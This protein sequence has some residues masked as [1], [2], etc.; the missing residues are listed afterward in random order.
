MQKDN[1]ILHILRLLG[2]LSSAGN[3]V[4]EKDYTM[5]KNTINER[6]KTDINTGVQMTKYFHHKSPDSQGNEQAYMLRR[7]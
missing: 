2:I 5:N 3:K 6:E 1:Y 4:R 7:S